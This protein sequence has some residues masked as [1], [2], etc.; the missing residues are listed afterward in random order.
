MRRSTWINSR[1][2]AP[3]RLMPAVLPPLPARLR[4]PE[5]G[6]GGAKFRGMRFVAAT[7]R[8]RRRHSETANMSAISCPYC[9][10]IVPAKEI[11]DGWCENCGKKLPPSFFLGPRRADI[12][13]RR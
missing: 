8:H 6:A 9:D 10:V 7:N 2:G 4:R 13:A 5:R 11:D 12:S 1:D 3:A